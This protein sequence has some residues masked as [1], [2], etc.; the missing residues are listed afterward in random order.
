M[1][2]PKRRKSKSKVRTKRSHHALKVPKLVKCKNCQEY[3][4]PHKVCPI[5]GFYKG[6][7]KVIPKVKK[8]KESKEGR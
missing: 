8:S 4:L 3:I 6:E 1:A 5:C 2:V 7:V